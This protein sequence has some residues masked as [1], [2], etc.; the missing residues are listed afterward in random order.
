MFA[1]LARHHGDDDAARE[2][3]LATG[4]GRQPG[5]IAYGRHLA[6]QLDIPEEQIKQLSVEAGVTR[7]LNAL[8][9]ELTRRGWD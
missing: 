1:A 7:S 3:V 5:T 9:T 6:R 2:F 8:R 4:G